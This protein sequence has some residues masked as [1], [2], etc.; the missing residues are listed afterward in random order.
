MN[1]SA[2]CR[3]LAGM[4][5]HK[6]EPCTGGRNVFETA[7]YTVSIADNLGSSGLNP[8]HRR[9]AGG[10]LDR[11]VLSGASLM[12]T[13][14]DI[15][16]FV[17]HEPRPGHILFSGNDPWRNTPKTQPRTCNP[18]FGDSVGLFGSCLDY[19]GNKFTRTSSL[20]RH[21]K[22]VRKTSPHASGSIRYFS[23]P[24]LP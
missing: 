3:L 5:V 20:T 14:S 4:P 18:S 8:P 22:S 6:G 7:S 15:A 17:A 11:M 9:A 19:F 12:L 2:L 16:V 23:V 1:R 24:P 13:R 10:S 21:G